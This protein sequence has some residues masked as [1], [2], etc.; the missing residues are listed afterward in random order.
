MISVV[1]SFIILL[2]ITGIFV[3][4][5]A[6]R[7]IDSFINFSLDEV[8]Q[9][10]LSRV[11]IYFSNSARSRI[12]WIAQV[13]AEKGVAYS[14]DPGFSEELKEEVQKYLASEMNVINADG[15]VTASS[16]SRNIGFDIHNDPNM[17][18]FLCLLDGETDYYVHDFITTIMNG[19]TLMYR[20]VAMPTLGGM[21]LEGVDQETYAIDKESRLGTQVRFDRLGRGG[22]FLLTDQSGVIVSSTEGIHEGETFIPGSETEELAQSGRIVKEDVFGTESYIGVRRDGNHLIIAVYPLSEAWGQWTISMIILIVIYSSV[23][24]VI[25]LVMRRLITGNVVKGVY[26]LDGSL[27]R[28]T[29][30][31]LDERADFR[32]SVEFDELSDGIN[33]MVDRLKGLIKEA[34][35]RI[36]AELALAA[37]TQASILP[38]DFPAF[39]ERDEF[40]LYAAMD[41]AKEV[42]GDF[43]DFFL[44]DDDHLALVMG[45][46]SGKGI[47]ASMFMVMAKDKIRN[48]VMKHGMDVS[49]AVSEVNT[50]LMKENGAKLFVTVWLGV[51]TVST[52][53]MDYVNA[54]HE[55]PAISRGGEEFRVDE[56]VHSAPVAARKK[57]VFEAGAFE[58][59]FGDILYLYTDGVTEAND[60]EGKM[61]GRERML[62]ALNKDREAAMK[63]IDANV[64]TAVV[65]FARGAAQFDD[66]TTLIIKFMGKEI[67]RIKTDSYILSKP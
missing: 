51:L 57:T 25:F 36:D 60:P 2:S 44:V 43:Y 38:H 62:D 5:Y 18:E 22:Y 41:P 35:E 66:T 24:A 10:T 40:E 50:E 37:K 15:I 33:F 19:E 42:G 55:Y 11:E 67:D 56:D 3:Y 4:L 48:S 30:G 26:S 6:R 59:G 31:D 29:A 8:E 17:S 54:G 23:F 58:L 14:M 49:A 27:K 52:G 7:S 45:D 12:E 20:G 53:H 61:F 28:I 1:T 9:V 64:R 47:P 46:V 65:G 34:E 16:D 39:P 63:D 21:Y 32:V 13:L